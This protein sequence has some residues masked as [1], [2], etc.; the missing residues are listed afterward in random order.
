[1]GR[2]PLERPEPLI[3]RVYA[4]VAYRVGDGADAEDVTSEVFENALRYRSSYDPAKGE[5]IAWLLGIARRCVASA[6]AARPAHVAELAESAAPG[7][8]AEQAVE[9]LALNEAFS[10]LSERDQ[11]LI[12]LRYGADM[13]AS[14]IAWMLEIPT[15]NAAEVAVHRAVARLRE[16]LLREDEPSSASPPARPSSAY[17]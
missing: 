5:P 13:K 2:D 11:E 14:Q 12:A 7:D 10:R 15:T 4:Y 16:E 3:R 1:M 9:R 17:L 8:L 6:L